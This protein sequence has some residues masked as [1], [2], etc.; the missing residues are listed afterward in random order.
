MQDARPRRWLRIVLIALSVL[1]VVYAILG[2]FVA[3]GFIRRELVK[4]AGGTLHR[5]VSV[6]RVKLNPFALS[7]TVDSLRV[8]DRDNSTLLAWDRF[9]IN[10]QLRSIFKGEIIFAEVKLVGPY[11]RL[12]LHADGTMNISD[13]L[14]SLKAAP[15]EPKPAKPK[16]PPVVAI[17]ALNIENAHFD[18]VDSSARRPF[19]TTI[20]PWRIDL[21]QFSTRS[22]NQGQYS[23]AG[24]TSGGGAFSWNGTIALDPLRTAGEFSLDSLRL[25]RAGPYYEHTVGFDVAD[26]LGSLRGKYT[27]DFTPKK[28]ILRLA[29]AALRVD[30]LALVIRGQ[31]DSVIQ[32][33]RLEISGID[34]N[35]PE[36]DVRVGSV[37]SAGRAA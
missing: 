8:A 16:P 28:E 13:I 12:L 23:F 2:F 7:L 37:A 22:D 36:H 27:V 35:V 6:A 31:P 3:P 20:G 34:V 9:Y 11:G 18:L 33:R 21:K 10:F 19:T 15:K 1:V 32:L 24:R 29:E 26:G 17:D 4:Q 30:R 14:D 5:E 25:S